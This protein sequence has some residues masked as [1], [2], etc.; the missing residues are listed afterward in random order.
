MRAREPEYG[1]DL[2]I[3]DPLGENHCHL[4]I[5]RDRAG[6][7][8]ESAYRHRGAPLVALGLWP[9]RSEHSQRTV[10]LSTLAATARRNCPR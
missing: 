2:S 5:A 1:G 6:V 4:P 3:W 9:G 8:D 10:A 7:L